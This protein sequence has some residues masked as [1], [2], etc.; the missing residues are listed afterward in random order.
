MRILTN[1]SIAAMLSLGA[2]AAVPTNS[3]AQW[4]YEQGVSVDYPPPPLPIYDQPPMP[5]DGYL[6]TPGYWAWDPGYGDYYWVPGAWV[7]PPDE[8]LLWTPAW[9][10]WED[11]AYLFHPGYW[12]PDIGYYG[13]VDYGFGY[14]GYGYQ[15]GYWRG[16]DFFYNRCGQ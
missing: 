2:L 8:G 4:G 6:W 5:D 14:T 13:G 9:W 16:R 10:G 3:Q 15:G 1:A 7:L 11:G 12:A